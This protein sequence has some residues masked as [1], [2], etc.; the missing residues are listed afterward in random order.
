MRKEVLLIFLFSFIM[1]LNFISSEHIIS[2]PSFSVGIAEESQFTITI[3]NSDADNITEVNITL[4]SSLI[5]V[6]GTQSTNSVSEFT[7]TSDTLSWKNSSYVISSQDLGENV[8]DFSF[9]A[10]ST[11]L[12]DFNLTVKTTNSTST[13]ETKISLTIADTGNPEVTLI[14][15]SDG[16]ED[17]DGILIF[18]CSA[19]DNFELSTLTLYI[20]D[21]N[22]SEIYKNSTN[23]NGTSNE[24]SWDY[25]FVSDGDYIWNCFVNDSSGNSDWASNRTITINTSPICTPNWSCT[26]WSECI[27]NSQTRICTDLNSCNDLSDKPSETQSCIPCVPNWDCTAWSPEEC[28]KNETQTR[29]CTDL[30]ECGTEEGKPSESRT[31]SYEKKSSLIFLIIGVLILF[32]VVLMLFLYLKNKNKTSQASQTPPSQPFSKPP[33]GGYPPSSTPAQPIPKSSNQYP[34]KNF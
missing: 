17:N 11:S 20:W 4:P 5:F 27:N 12:G 21:S 2:P 14:N 13:I 23:I 31:C 25:A 6:N 8:K 24:T 30:N 28:P 9:N 10:I 19:T 22:N 34:S 3:N 1:S 18:E 32:V 16:I 26:E 15:P 29:I 7:N 33:Y